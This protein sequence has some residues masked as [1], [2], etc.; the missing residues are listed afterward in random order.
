MIK[1]YNDVKMLLS[2]FMAIEKIIQKDD[3]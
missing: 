2:F 1:K 3:D